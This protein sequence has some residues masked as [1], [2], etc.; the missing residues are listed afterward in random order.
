M[1]AI[2]LKLSYLFS[3]ILVFFIFPIY[4]Q[5]FFSFFFDSFWSLLLI[6]FTSFTAGYYII[7]KLLYTY[8]DNAGRI[9]IFENISASPENYSAHSSE[10]S[11][12]S[13]LSRGII[14]QN[15]FGALQIQ[16]ARKHILKKALRFA[17]LLILLLG[18]IL[19]HFYEDFHYSQLSNQDINKDAIKTVGHLLRLAI[20][21]SSPDDLKYLDAVKKDDIIV[22]AGAYDKVEEVLEKAHIPFTLINPVHL[23][24]FKLKPSQIVMVNCPGDI[25]TIGALN[26]KKFI[27]DGGYLFTTDW[28]L[29]YT[30]NRIS[31][32]Y[33]TASGGKTKN[34]VIPIETADKTSEFV[35]GISASN[36]TPSWWEF[37]SFPIKIIDKDKVNIIIKSD[38]MKKNYDNEAVAVNYKFGKGMIIHTAAHFYQQQSA[39]ITSRQRGPALDY[40][41]DEMKIDL[42]RL[43]N[44]WKETLKNIKAGQIEDTYSVLRFIANVIIAKKK[45]NMAN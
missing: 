26:L 12:N 23:A 34:E 3:I 5:L 40:V 25:S 21:K 1:L 30:V 2:F 36:G 43:D 6:L 28:A 35:K 14:E 31:S 4:Y 45:V 27:E 18:P 20:E 16:D 9:V 42:A 7:Y 32:E 37:F 8:V 10:E 13:V 39:L 44:S 19:Y 29:M 11:A 33:I 38:R 22:V 17:L 24:D 15:P 41:K